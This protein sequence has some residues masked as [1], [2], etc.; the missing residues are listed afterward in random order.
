MLY[1]VICLIVYRNERRLTLFLIVLQVHNSIVHTQAMLTATNGKRV[2][3]IIHQGRHGADWL[4]LYTCIF[5]GGLGY[6]HFLKSVAHS[7]VL[8]G[9][10][11]KEMHRDSCT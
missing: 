6:I 11:A 2:T 10:L 4:I 8:Q 1:Y 5:W 9:Q 7:L 3:Q